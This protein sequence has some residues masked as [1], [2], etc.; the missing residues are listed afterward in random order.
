MD[1][2]T[3]PSIALPFFNVIKLG[4]WNQ[5]VLSNKGKVSC[6]KKQR[7][8]LMGLHLATDLRS[9]LKS[10]KDMQWIYNIYIM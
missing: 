3:P 1:T 5:P 10:Y 8:P 6:S 2:F 4:S 9:F 7:E